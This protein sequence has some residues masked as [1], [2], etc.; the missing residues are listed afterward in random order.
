LEYQG[1]HSNR[2]GKYIKKI[3]KTHSTYKILSR[4]PKLSKIYRNSGYE[5]NFIKQIIPDEVYNE[6]NSNFTKL[7]CNEC[8]QIHQIDNN[9]S[10]YI[11]ILTFM[12]CSIDSIKECFEL[13]YHTKFNIKTIIFNDKVIW[14]MTIYNLTPKN[15]AHDGYIYWEETEKNKILFISHI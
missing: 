9:K 7:K 15:Y 13:Y 10:K 12:T 5:I 4:L 2:N 14:T 1:Y 8:N 3:V 11:D 6:I